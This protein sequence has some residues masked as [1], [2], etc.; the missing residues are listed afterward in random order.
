MHINSEKETNQE[1][2]MHKGLQ[3][4]WLVFPVF[5][6]RYSDPG[7]KDPLFLFFADC[8]S[9]CYGQMLYSFTDLGQCLQHRLFAL[10]LIGGDGQHWVILEA[11]T[12]TGSN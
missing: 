6:R 2:R 9:C 8:L 5:L 12:E 1:S 7:R 3:M 11:A 4:L 10:N